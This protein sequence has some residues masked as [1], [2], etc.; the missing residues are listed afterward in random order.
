[1]N[2][3][4]RNQIFTKIFA[5]YVN[6]QEGSIAEAVQEHGITKV[7]EM[8]EEVFDGLSVEHRQRIEELKKVFSGE[9]YDLE[10][11]LAQTEDQKEE[12][13]PTEKNEP[14]EEKE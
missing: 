6:V 14:E 10:K 8:P 4:D 7:L 9:F 13:E 3:W 12:T 2:K 11:E 5:D 1:M